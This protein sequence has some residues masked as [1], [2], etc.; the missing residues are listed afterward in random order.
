[1]KT[2]RFWLKSAACLAIAGSLSVV[3][4]KESFLNVT[5]PT[6]ISAGT[7]PNT[8]ADMDLMLIDLYGRLRNTYYHTDSF[9]RIGILLS[10]DADQGYN[11]SEFNEFGQNVVLPSTPTVSFLWNNSYENVTKCNSFFEGLAK[12]RA[13][14]LVPE[15][16][17]AL[18]IQE[19]QARFLRA[20]H[21]FH[22]LNVFG[23]TAIT[24]AADR[25]RPG[26]PIWDKVPGSIAETNRPRAT[27]GE[28]WDFII[29]DL[30]QAETL[31]KGKVW[32]AA[33]KPRVDEWAVKSLLGK[34][35]VFTQQ[36]NLA[37]TT[38]RDVIDNSGKRLVPYQT[39]RTMF[40]GQNEYN[41][42]SIF[43]VNFTPD[44]RDQWNI[45]KNTATYHGIF[46]SPSYVEA[47]G[48]E[49]TNGFGN[50]FIHDENLKR[51]G[52][53]DTT[54]VNQR[55]PDY[56]AKSLQVRSSKSVDPR[57][58]VST[59]QP[60]VDSVLIGNRWRKVAK[61]RFEGFDGKNM[62]AWC[63]RKYVLVDRSVWDGDATSLGINQYVL[64]LADI[65]L[66]YAEAQ[67]ALGNNAVALEFV[68]RVHRRAYDVNPL[69]A[70]TFD[71]KTLS[72]RTVT[73]TAT[74]PLANDPL[75]YERWAELLCEGH[76]WFDVCRWRIG[77]QE[78]AYYKRVMSGPL[79]WNDRKYAMPL[80]IGEMDNNTE[81]R[82]ND[83]Y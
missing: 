10:H 76:W 31:L 21:Y 64:R 52:F 75:R 47:D 15:Q 8:V 39:L 19:G 42:E 45:V 71:Y 35:Y 80:P 30:K 63:H 79:V 67:K 5:D 23:A 34:S 61:N 57:L 22:L 27:V 14:N 7:F 17:T 43:E 11:G 81:A 83:G 25:A 1:M 50:L 73:V 53:N 82:Q 41:A 69:V 46:I 58:Y 70:S 36:W 20:F 48:S 12:L 6:V 60:Y 68:N 51:Y 38:L 65:Y 26:I 59:L 54:A 62:K 13:G 33:N 4:C 74:D 2:Q 44:Q 18:D 56:I 3:S 32:D 29:N 55:R 37:S 66:L 72:D 24:S 49:P 77:A 9:R 28:V 78:A 16:K 40:N